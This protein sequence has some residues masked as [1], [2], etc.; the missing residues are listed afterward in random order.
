MIKRLTQREQ[1]SIIAVSSFILLF[2]GLQFVVWPAFDKRKRLGRTLQ[3]KAKILEKMIALKSEHDAVRQRTDLSK[4]HLE[5][6]EKGFTLF[7]FL[8]R[9]SG[10]A[11]IKDHITYMKPSTTVQKNSPYKTARVEMKLQSITL[12]QL[13]AYL[14]MV[15]T[16]KNMVNIKRLS[17]SKTGTQEGYINAVLQVETVEN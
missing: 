1:Y 16:S 3:V 8:D 5:N 12:Q 7:A 2:I 11:G 13:T 17:I 10:E 6:R 9:L 4:S 15:E 14:Y